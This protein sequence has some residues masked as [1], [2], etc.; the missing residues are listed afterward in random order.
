MVLLQLDVRNCGETEAS[1][2][3]TASSTAWSVTVHNLES[4]LAAEERRAVCDAGHVSGK[5]GFASG[6][7][8]QQP[9]QE[10]NPYAGASAAWQQGS[11]GPPGG[12]QQVV[13]LHVD[14]RHSSA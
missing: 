4:T 2:C 7:P 6:V 9:Q 8:Q 1:H 14:V 3:D 11:Y 10:A 5:D 12:R 13:L